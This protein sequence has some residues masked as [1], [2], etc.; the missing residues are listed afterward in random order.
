MNPTRSP[1]TAPAHGSALSISVGTMSA[2][3]KSSTAGCPS[4][5]S[6]TAGRVGIQPE[7]RYGNGVAGASIGAHGPRGGSSRSSVATEAS[8]LHGEDHGHLPEESAPHSGDNVSSYR[9]I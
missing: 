5:E 6:T 7:V 8:R 4:Q 3:E 2:R 9:Y 1:Q